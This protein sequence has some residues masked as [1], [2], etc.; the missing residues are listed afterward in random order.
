VFE[1]FLNEKELVLLH[2]RLRRQIRPDEDS[3]R[4]YPLCQSCCAKVETVGG[5]QPNDPVTVIV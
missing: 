2:E 3:L 5:P 4:F 1:R